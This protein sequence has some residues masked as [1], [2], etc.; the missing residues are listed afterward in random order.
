MAGFVRAPQ[1]ASEPCC[2]EKM[3]DAQWRHLPRDK[4]LLWA[5]GSIPGA[6]PPPRQEAAQK[7]PSSLVA[8]GGR[9]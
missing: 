6:V 4:Q 2:P 9:I 1:A 5:R 3:Q 8:T 7:H